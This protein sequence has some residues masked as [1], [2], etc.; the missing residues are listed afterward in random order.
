V[1][2]ARLRDLDQN[3]IDESLG[4]LAT[5]FG[6]AVLRGTVLLPTDEFFPEEGPQVPEQAV[7]PEPAFWS[8][9]S[10]TRSR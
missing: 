8:R 4:W 6:D 9:R 2:F 10:F 1:P 7:I 5:E 3:W